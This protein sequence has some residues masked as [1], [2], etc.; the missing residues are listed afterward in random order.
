MGLFARLRQDKAFSYRFL[1][2]GLVLFKILLLLA[3]L[4][5]LYFALYGR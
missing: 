3:I 5:V 2:A 4:L 1:L